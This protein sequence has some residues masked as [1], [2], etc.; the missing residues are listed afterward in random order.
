[1]K[2]VSTQFDTVLLAGD[3]GASRT[4]CGRNKSFLEINGIPLLLYVLKALEKAERVNRICIIGPHDNLLKALD[5]HNSFLEHTKDI[6]ICQQDES[7]FSK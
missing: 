2:K 1:M 6:T 3:T 4:I 7:L 5:D